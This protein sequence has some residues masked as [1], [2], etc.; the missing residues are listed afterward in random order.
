MSPEHRPLSPGSPYQIMQAVPSAKAKPA[1]QNFSLLVEVLG[2]PKAGACGHLR[3]PC[4]ALSFL[5]FLIPSRY[6]G[7]PALA[8]LLRL[9]PQLSQRGPPCWPAG[10]LPSACPPDDGTGFSHWSHPCQPLSLIKPLASFSLFLDPCHPLIPSLITHIVTK[11]SWFV[12]CGFVLMDLYLRHLIFK[13]ITGVS[14]VFQRAVQMLGALWWLHR[15]TKSPAMAKS[16]WKDE[17]QTPNLEDQRPETI[18]PKV[19]TWKVI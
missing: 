14:V 18:G 17:G 7:C 1:F 15:R 2:E 6:T 5:L 19:H 3:N 10:I 13:C 9:E 4:S 11:K 16:H 8:T 12:Q